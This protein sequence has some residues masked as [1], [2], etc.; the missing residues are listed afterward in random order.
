MTKRPRPTK[1]ERDIAVRHRKI[2]AVCI[3]A[4]IFVVFLILAVLT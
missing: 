4:T 1:R 2:G 3:G